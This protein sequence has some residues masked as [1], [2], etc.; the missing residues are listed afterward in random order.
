MVMVMVMEERM[1]QNRSSGQ[2]V[3]VYMCPGHSAIG[4]YSTFTG[5]TL[6]FN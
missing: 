2:S 5:H 1:L 4:R 3:V 6:G